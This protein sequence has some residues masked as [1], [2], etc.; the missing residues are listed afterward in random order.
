M[1]ECV[2]Q[3]LLNRTSVF[4]TDGPQR[5]EQS[6]FVWIMPWVVQKVKSPGLALWLWRRHQ[7]VG[8]SVCLSQDSNCLLLWREGEWWGSVEGGGEEGRWTGGVGK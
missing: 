2:S 1:I 5:K 4:S 7:R 6:V 3:A 8:G